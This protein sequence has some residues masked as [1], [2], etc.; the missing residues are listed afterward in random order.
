MVGGGLS[1]LGA[2]LTLLRARRS[3]LV[4][5]AGRP[6]NAP[7]AH[8]H[9][10]LT[11]DGMSPLDL[12]EAGRL[13]VRG[14]GGT[15][16]VGEVTSLERLA[17][18]G[19]Q[20]VLSDGTSHRA[21]R[22]LVTT[23]LVD[24]LPE[25]P[26]LRERWGRDVVHC[27]F[28]F[29]WEVRDRPLGVLATG[30]LAVT[31]ALMWWQW[32]DDVI[33]LRHTVPEPTGEQRAR[34]TARGIRVVDG[35]VV[36][37]ETKDD[38]I[39]G[40]RLASGRV[41]ARRVLVVGP[42]FAARHALLDGLGVTVVEHPLGIG[43][44]VK[45]DP[46]G[47]AAPGVYVAGNVT[48]VTAGVMQSTAS[49]VTAAASINA[50]L[51]A[52]DTARAVAAHAQFVQEWREFRAGWERFLK[53]PFGWL[54]TVSMNWVEDATPRHYPGQPGLWWQEGNRLYVDPQGQT[55]SYDGESFTAVRGLDLSDAPDDVR[56]TAGEL[57]IGVTYREQYLL[58]TY[59]PQAPERADFRG[60]PT[61][62]PD[63]RWML[64][65][66]IEPYAAPKSVPV[67]SVGTDS[68]TYTSPGVVRFS[69]AGREH[70]L[71]LT[72]SVNGMA[73]IFTDATSGIT[74]YGACRSLS[75]P[76]PDENGTVVLDFNRALNL[77]CAF[78]GMPVCPVAPPENRLPFAV[79]AGEKTPYEQVRLRG[80]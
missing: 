53:Q 61:Y 24:V 4:V 39:T 17:D 65:G 54:S 73:T 5:D 2:A 66:R 56:I 18:G 50:D 76:Q 72:T 80:W 8:A 38:G 58:V 71:S 26:G 52:E 59:D 20:A 37:I 45:A 13:E 49:G 31:Q 3:V 30:P 79:E 21:R 14:Y 6:R 64:T 27:P 62:E 70:T 22:V 63:Q 32:S 1:G 15:I 60:V 74:T 19:F 57:Q 77:P 44:Q 11:R 12:L 69:Y 68:H 78:N 51:T 55:M 36:A 43:D 33:L 28:C 9:G 16:I 23:G 25:I 41:V 7:A 48:D 10:Y 35:E 29:G 42:W 46:T 40:V 67:D 34:L 75:I 47:F